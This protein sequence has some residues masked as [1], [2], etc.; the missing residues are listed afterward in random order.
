[1]VDINLDKEFWQEI[2]ELGE[3][4]WDIGRPS[5]PMA[6]YIEQ[7]TDKSLEILIPGAGNAWEAEHLFTNGFANVNVLDIAPGAIANFKDRL[8]GFPESQLHLQNFFNHRGCYDL[9]LEQTF[10]SALHP[11]L[12]EKYV[13]HQHGLLKEGGKLVGLLFVDPLNEDHPPFGGNR[14]QYIDIFSTHFEIDKMETAH[15]SI[16]KR[17]GRELFFIC[18]KTE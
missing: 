7:L 14:Q 8:P 11:E 12:R 16:E 10:F 4:G 13:A 9:I 2:Y 6:G 3:M 18:K 1:M 15:N 5:R 17:E